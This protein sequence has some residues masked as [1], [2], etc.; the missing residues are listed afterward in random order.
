M[1]KED[2]EIAKELQANPEIKDFINE[3]VT[4][5]KDSIKILINFVNELSILTDDSEKQALFNKYVKIAEDRKVR[6]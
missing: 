3:A 5:D 1:N 6:A 2:L 4:L